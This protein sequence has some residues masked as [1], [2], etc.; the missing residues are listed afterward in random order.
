MKYHFHIFLFLGLLNASCHSEMRLRI[1]GGSIKYIAFVRVGDDEIILKDFE[2]SDTTFGVMI[3]LETEVYEIESNNDKRNYFGPND[4][5]I[6]IS[7]SLRDEEYSKSKVVLLSSFWNDSSM[8]SMFIPDGFIKASR[9]IGGDSKTGYSS[10]FVFSD[11]D[12]FKN[13]Y[14]NKEFDLFNYRT[15]A[16]ELKTPF[17]FWTSDKTLIGSLDKGNE[18]LISIQFSDGRNLELEVEQ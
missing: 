1:I 7:G 12:D 18:F 3:Q 14:N 17:F 4:S 13:S 2:K 9:G 15:A 5:I 11:F 8:N 16:W 6:S 10:S